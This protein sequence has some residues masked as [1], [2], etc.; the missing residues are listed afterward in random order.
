MCAAL[1]K[2]RD[3]R[4]PCPYHRPARESTAKTASLVKPTTRFLLLLLVLLALALAGLSGFW[5][6]SSDRLRD[7]LEAWAFERRAEGWTV[8]WNGPEIS[9][10]PFRLVAHFGDPALASPGRWR[11]RGPDVRGQAAV[12]D[13]LLLR[14]QGPGRHDL[15]WGAFG[16]ELNAEIEAATAEGTLRL[17]AGGGIE[18]ARVRFEA[19]S[20]EPEGLEV[21]RIERLAVTGGPAPAEPYYDEGALL[22]VEAAAH[23]V[24]LPDRIESPLGQRIERLL[25]GATLTGR[26]PPDGTRR[27]VLAGW[28]DSGGTLVVD[29]LTLDWG[30]VSLVGEG[31]A[32]LDELFRPLG[33]FSLEAR[34]L[35]EALDALREEGRIPPATAAAA[36]I[37]LFA[38]G[39]R[40]EDGGA[41]KVPVT[42]QDGFLLLGPVPL[43]P[44]RPLVPAEPDAASG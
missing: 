23:G 9:G 30:P 36:R 28:R 38:L 18:R 44:L 40:A 21:T 26:L 29:R 12:W 27:Q 15:S 16:E 42:L 11:W 8:A 10:F 39:G 14:L 25:F 24:L 41:V 35:L 19:L 32:T 37:A 6:W 31:T 33:A 4:W 43:L 5:F 1:G 22:R 2:E 7:S 20:I 3:R 34:G 17:L 13:P